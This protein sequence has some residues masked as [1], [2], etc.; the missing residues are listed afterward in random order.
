VARA[1]T[2]IASLQVWQW[3]DGGHETVQIVGFDPDQEMGAPWNL[4]SG[5][6]EL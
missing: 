4:V 2:Y 5:I 1:T 3:P 6:S